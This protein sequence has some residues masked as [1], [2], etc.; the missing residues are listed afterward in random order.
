MTDITSRLPDIEQY[1]LSLQTKICDQLSDIDGQAAFIKDEWQRPDGER[2]RG[3][4]ISRV[5][6]EGAAIEKGG[7][8]FSYVHA[9]SLPA[10]ATVS[11]PELANSPYRAMGVSLVVHPSNPYAPTTHA[12]VRVFAVFPEGQAPVCW[13]GGGFDLTP[14][15]LFPEDAKAWH[16]QAHDLCQP[17]GESVYPTYKQ[18][19]DD[20]FYLPHRNETRGVGGL[21]YDDQSSWALD[22]SFGFMQAVGDGF[23]SAYSDILSRRKDTPFGDQERQFQLYR[24]GRYVEFNLLYDRGTIFGLQSGGRIESILM[25]MPPLVRFDYDWQPEPGSREAELYDALQDPKDWL[26]S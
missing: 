16:Q 8:N 12:N 26:N 13:F 14:Y 19:C 23:L 21:F 7:V 20:Y 4:G 6:T 18:W 11:R 17:F 2:L 9:D 5:L 22:D 25:S 24:R 10:A 3:Y 15:Y 1:L